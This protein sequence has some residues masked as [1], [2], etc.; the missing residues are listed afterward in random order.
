MH[1][2]VRWK[3][4]AGMFADADQFCLK[5]E[6]E[7]YLR[8]IQAPALAFRAGNEDPQAVADWE[9][10]C[11][12]HPNSAAIGWEGYGHWLHQERPAEFNRALLDW[13]KTARL[14]AHPPRGLWN[15]T[16]LPSGSSTSQ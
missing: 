11:F 13:L 10:S 9:R 15:P 4:M 2:E 8:C 5:P 1:P 16:A 6:A 12:Q 3:A 7:A 14:T